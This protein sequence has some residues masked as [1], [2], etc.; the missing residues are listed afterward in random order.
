MKV[1]EVEVL[2]V[3]LP[4]RRAHTWATLTTA[5]GRDYVLVRVRSD[6]G[7]EGWGE[8]PV[9][10]DWGGDWGRYFGESVSIAE[11]VVTRTDQELAETALEAA[12]WLGEPG[13]LSKAYMFMQTLAGTTPNLQHTG[14]LQ[15][16]R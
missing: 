2:L 1:T 4:T 15:P 12:A 9:L 7:D 8:A 14:S 5:I 11:L 13:P 10:K 16:E 3:S 6:E